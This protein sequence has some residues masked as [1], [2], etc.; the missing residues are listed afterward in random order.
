MRGEGR[1]LLYAEPVGFASEGAP[2]QRLL[3]SCGRADAAPGQLFFLQ[4]VVKGVLRPCHVGFVEEQ[5]GGYLRTIEGNT[6]TDGSR[7]G[8]G[9]FRRERKITSLL[10][11]VEIE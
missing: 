5:E 11:F 10:G 2:N 6:N 7:N 8:V 3:V 9:V 4:G 1:E